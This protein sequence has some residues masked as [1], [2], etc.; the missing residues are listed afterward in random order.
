MTRYSFNNS[1]CVG[2]FLHSYIMVDQFPDAIKEI[3][4]RCGKEM[5]FRIDKNG[6]S[7]NLHY[8]AHHIR[9]ALQPWHPLFPHEYPQ[10]ANS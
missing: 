8:L 6:N 5:I 3:C 2:S 4:T 10:H 7:D 9:S 1:K